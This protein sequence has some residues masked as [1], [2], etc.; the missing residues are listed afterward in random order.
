M[1][2]VESLSVH[3]TVK[4]R[5][6]RWGRMAARASHVLPELLSRPLLA[7]SVRR[8]KVTTYAGKTKL[9]TERCTARWEGRQLVAVLGDGS[10]VLAGET[11]A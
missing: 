10:E 7:W 5:G 3:V 11:H 1:P 8:I 2:N 6:M 9:G 4:V